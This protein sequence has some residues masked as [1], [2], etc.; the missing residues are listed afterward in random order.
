MSEKNL[1]GFSDLKN[2]F[3]D[4]FGLNRS[5][6]AVRKYAEQLAKICEVMREAHLLVVKELD[7]IEQATS[8]KD[9]LNHVNNLLEEP[10]RGFFHTKGLCREFAESGLNLRKLIGPT[11][12]TEILPISDGQKSTLGKFSEELVCREGEVARLYIYNIRNIG[13]EF[14]NIYAGQDLDKLK[15]AANKARR[16][17]TDQMADFDSLAK[18]FRLI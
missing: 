12:P 14:S 8:S 4:L 17:L 16:T 13:G 7:A 5:Q 10:L 18:K 1:V 15:V 6:M 2:V 9:A 11:E 3:E